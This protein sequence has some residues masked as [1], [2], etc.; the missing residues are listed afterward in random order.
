MIQSGYKPKIISQPLVASCFV[1]VKT[2]IECRCPNKHATEMGSAYYVTRRPLLFPLFER[3]AR[4]KWASPSGPLQVGLDYCIR[5]GP[6]VTHYVPSEVGGNLGIHH[7]TP[8]QN[9]AEG[10]VFDYR[11][12]RGGRHHQKS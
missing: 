10:I 6:A 12:W 7:D 5:P 11:A 1:K 2:R 4:K 3:R 9:P 8:L